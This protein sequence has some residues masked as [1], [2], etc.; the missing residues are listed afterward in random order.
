MN[1]WSD[2]EKWWQQPELQELRR[3]F[4]KNYANFSTDWYLQ[5]ESEFKRL[6]LLNERE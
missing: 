3:A 6:L 5:W 2:I 1:V 4:C